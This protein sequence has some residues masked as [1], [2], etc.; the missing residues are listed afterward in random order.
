MGENLVLNMAGKGFRVSV[1]NRTASKTDR[2]LQGRA[3]D[4]TIY[5]YHDVA[6]F[7]AALAYYDRL[8]SARLPANLLQARRNYFRAHTYGRLDAP[9]GEFFHTNWT[10]QGGSTAST[11]YTK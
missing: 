11:A 3:K 9:G 6:D 1:Y 2:F 8:R 7:I 5:G 10:G 4:T